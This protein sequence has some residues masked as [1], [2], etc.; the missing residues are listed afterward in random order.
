MQPFCCYKLKFFSEKLKYFNVNLVARLET[1]LKNQQGICSYE[2]LWIRFQQGDATALGE[3][4]KRFYPSMLNYG[5]KLNPDREMVKDLLQELFLELWTRREA[6]TLPVSIKAYLFGAFRN[7]IYKARLGFL[8]NIEIDALPFESE[9][10]EREQSIEFYLILE[11]TQQQYQH[12]LS[13]LISTL[14]KR[15]QEI[16]FLHYYEGLGCE[17]VTTIMGISRQGVY[18]LLSR[19]LKELRKLWILDYTPILTLILYTLINQ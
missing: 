13:R 5:L 1:S 9:W 19:T 12:Y 8:P 4:S 3:L 16:L 6:I 10:A 2:H 15:Q 7:K 17:Q 18:N 14:P 11:E